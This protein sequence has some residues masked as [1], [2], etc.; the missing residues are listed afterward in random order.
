[1]YASKILKD[2]RSLGTSTSSETFAQ[3]NSSKSDPTCPKGWA[4]KE[5]KKPTRFCLRQTNY[6]N[7]RFR[8]G[9]LD[10]SAKA[11]PNLVSKQMRFARGPDGARVFK[12]PEFLTPQQIASYFSRLSNKRKLSV[13]TEDDFK[14]AEVECM[15]DVIVSEISAAVTMTE[16]TYAKHPVICCDTNLCE[17]SQSG[18]LQ[19]TRLQ[20]L[21]SYCESLGIQISISED[22]R[23]KNTYLKKLNTYLEQCSCHL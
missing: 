8:E 21:R 16:S 3:V 15:H 23:Q 11:D 22:K 13:D 1:M 4:L 18:K 10:K 17:L 20:L 2:H 14:S 19:N 6:L 9:E 12:M 5:T 7:D